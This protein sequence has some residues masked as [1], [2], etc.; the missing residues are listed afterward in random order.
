MKSG[1]ITGGRERRRGIGVRW[2]DGKGGGED[3]VDLAQL[4]ELLIIISAGPY[5]PKDPKERKV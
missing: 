2:R 4:W 1:R 3:G 5:F